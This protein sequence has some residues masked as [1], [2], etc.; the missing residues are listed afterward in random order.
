LNQT[1]IDPKIKEETEK[2]LAKPSGKDHS[3]T[4]IKKS[5]QYIL[6]EK[7]TN[8][9]EFKTFEALISK[10]LDLFLELEDEDEIVSIQPGFES[11]FLKIFHS[12]NDSFRQTFTSQLTILTK[13]IS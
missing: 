1:S 4:F 11:A 13:Y 7:A 12:S 9:A 3:S 2:L 5:I 8:F 6:R 10:S